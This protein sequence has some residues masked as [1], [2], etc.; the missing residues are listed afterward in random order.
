MCNSFSTIPGESTQDKANARE[1]MRIW[2]C[3]LF[4]HWHHF[5]I[6]FFRFVDG[7]S[8][9]THTRKVKQ[10][11]FSILF[12]SIFCLLFG[13]LRTWLIHWHCVTVVV[14]APNRQDTLEIY[15]LVLN[16]VCRKNPKIFHYILD[17]IN[18]TE[19][20]N[21]AHET[22]MLCTNKNNWMKSRKNWFM[23]LLKTEG[24]SFRFLSKR[25]ENGIPSSAKERA[26]IS[27]QDLCEHWNKRKHSALS[28]WRL[29]LHSFLT[30]TFSNHHGD[31]FIFLNAAF[32]NCFYF[33]FLVFHLI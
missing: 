31:N 1:R 8:S 5:A 27:N 24:K 17:H 25:E 19:T 12:P 7:V 28:S 20:M 14:G 4:R 10:S 33:F 29:F 9:D 16:H 26:R 15:V 30:F 3:S 6:Y 32:S 23:R 18:S 11:D 22:K 13:L 2:I 21:I